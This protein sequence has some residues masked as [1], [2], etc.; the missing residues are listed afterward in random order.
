MNNVLRFPAAQNPQNT[1]QMGGARQ[2]SPMQ[3]IMDRFMSGIQPEQI[4]EQMAGPE[5]K[6]ARQIIHGKNAAQLRTIA[7]NMAQQRGVRLEELAA[8]LGVK[9]PG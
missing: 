4:L 6:Q 9:L 7:M 2:T 5:V 8:Q 3:M 1:Q